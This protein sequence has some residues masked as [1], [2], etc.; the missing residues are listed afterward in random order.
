VL[1][2][3]PQ[4]THLITNATG[5]LG[6]SCS[7][8]TDHGGHAFT[9][10]ASDFISPSCAPSDASGILGE[11]KMAGDLRNDFLPGCRP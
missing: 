11:H 4:H 1:Q 2:P 9:L 8:M 6:A 7:F 10:H 3:F 5:V